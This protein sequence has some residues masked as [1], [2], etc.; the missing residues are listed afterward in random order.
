MNNKIEQVVIYFIYFVVVC[1][2]ISLVAFFGSEIM[3]GV[4]FYDFAKD[5]GSLLAGL[6]AVFAAYFTVHAHKQQ[7][8]KESLNQERQQALLALLSIRE[9]ISLLTR[10]LE[11]GEDQFAI[12][13]K[14]T[15]PTLQAD[16]LKS[17]LLV[18][19]YFYRKKY[20]IEC[21]KISLIILNVELFR[22]YIY[23]FGS[24]DTKHLSLPSKA[25]EMNALLEKINLKNKELNKL[26]PDSDRF[27]IYDE[28]FLF[29]AYL[30][31][32][33]TYTSF[34]IGWDKLFENIVV[35]LVDR[36]IDIDDMS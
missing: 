27:L 36:I 1:F 6:M 10:Y 30:N 8:R 5:H 7:S 11:F 33:G 21:K 31:D 32:I 9:N 3:G 26:V 24:S 13:S 20:D 28:N 14:Q 19:G 16:I 35:T 2:G 23:W 15:F 4:S 34:S 29:K 17:A 25:R 22:K 12:L 18:R